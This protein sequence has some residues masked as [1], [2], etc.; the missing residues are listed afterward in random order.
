M[1]I[2]N[3]HFCT[4]LPAKNCGMEVLSIGASFFLE[5]ESTKKL[6]QVTKLM[7]LW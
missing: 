7:F 2:Y 3:S 1:S 4:L 6:I 5:V